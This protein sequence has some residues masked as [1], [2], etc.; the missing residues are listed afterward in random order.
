MDASVQGCRL[1]DLGQFASYSVIRAKAADSRSLAMVVAKYFFEFA[2][3]T[4][5]S[6]T[7]R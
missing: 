6:L 1:L 4:M 2:Q 7:F 3:C 5:P